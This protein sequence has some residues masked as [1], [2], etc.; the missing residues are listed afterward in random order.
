[1][2]T[3]LVRYQNRKGGNEHGREVLFEATSVERV[4]LQ[5]PN[6]AG[7]IVHRAGQKDDVECDHFLPVSENPEEDW[8]QVF[9]M[10]AAG[11]TVAQYIL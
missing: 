8:R 7:L 2:L 10:N 3:V 5:S 1:M 11:Q 6:P 9:V 4:P